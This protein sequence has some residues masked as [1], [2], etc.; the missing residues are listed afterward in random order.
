[1]F[2]QH[3]IDCSGVV[4]P[5]QSSPYAP[6][7]NVSAATRTH[8]EAQVMLIDQPGNRYAGDYTNSSEKLLQP[9]SP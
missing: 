3:S 4:I 7:A 2:L 9:R 6:R 8:F 5:T 1:M